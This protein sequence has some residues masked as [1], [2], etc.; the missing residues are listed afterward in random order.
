MNYDKTSLVEEHIKLFNGLNYEQRTIYDA[1]IGSV[2]ENTGGVFFIYG[3]RGTGKTYLWRTLICR[4]RSEE[5]IVIAVASSG[6]AA[7]L[8]PGGTTA[9]S[10]FQIPINV[11]DSSTCGLKQGS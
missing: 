3:H 2:T 4:L 9:H 5:K 7:L 1:V 10:R 6:I 11:T 8:L